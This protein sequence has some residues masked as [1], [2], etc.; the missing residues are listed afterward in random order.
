MNMEEKHKITIS[1]KCFFQKSSLLKKY[2]SQKLRFDIFVVELPVGGKRETHRR[3]HSISMRPL[4][5]SN[6]RPWDP[7]EPNHRHSLGHR[8]PER[9][10]DF[11]A[12]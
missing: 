12:K 2:V 8:I 1:L 11:T 7:F 5:G 9:R 10:Q 6:P 3:I 4:P